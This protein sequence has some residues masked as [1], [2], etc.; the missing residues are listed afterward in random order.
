MKLNF[1]EARKVL[2]LGLMIQTIFTILF[3]LSAFHY[4]KSIAQQLMERLMFSWSLPF[5]TG[6]FLGG[7]YNIIQLSNAEKCQF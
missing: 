4:I 2:A 3:Y 1:L 6:L 7:S 5:S